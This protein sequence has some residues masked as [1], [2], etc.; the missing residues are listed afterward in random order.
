[1]SELVIMLPEVRDVQVEFQRFASELETQLKDMDDELVRLELEVEKTE[2]DL[3]QDLKKDELAQLEER[4][5][6]FEQEAQRQLKYKEAELF[7]PLM[8]KV[9]D[10]VNAVG[11]QHGFIYIFDL[12][13]T[14]IVYRGGGED[15]TLLVKEKLGLLK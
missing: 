13:N 1:M 15:V 8:A 5:S 10:A 12:T 9:A 11:E 2:N 7:E 4:I 14:P 3:I 6:H